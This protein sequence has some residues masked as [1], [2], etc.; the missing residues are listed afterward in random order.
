MSAMNL[1]D[2]L[3]VLGEPA[4]REAFASFWD[5]A[6][7]ACPPATYAARHL[8]PEA[9]GAA[10]RAGRFFTP[11]PPAEL[12]GMARRIRETPAL[13]ALA[14]YAHWRLFDGPRQPSQAGWPALGACLGD[15][16]ELFYLVV[17]LGFIPS[18]Q[19][20]HRRLDLPASVMEGTGL[21]V[22]RYCDNFR[23]GRGR[24]GL[25]LNQFGWLANYMPPNLYFR[26]G[27][28]EYR[29]RTFQYPAHIF[30][31][32][33]D[34][35]T[36]ALSLGDLPFTAEGDRCL[37]DTPEP[38]GSWRS[39]FEETA[40][41]TRGT[42][43]TPWGRAGREPV[44]L[45]RDE[46]ECVLKPGDPILDMHIP[47]GGQMTPAAAESSMREAFHFFNTRF[48][49][50]PV[51][52]VVSCSW[53]FSNQIEAC[54][55]PEA[56]LAQLARRLYLLPS[57]SHANSGLW[58]VFLQDGGFN[59]ATARRDTSLQRA[60][61]DYLSRTGTPWHVNAMF[62]LGADLEAL[63]PDTY[64]RRWPPAGLGG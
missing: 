13:L 45:P 41:A 11:D 47:G 19:A 4:S 30:R 51:K 56:N 43:V 60:L 34:Q 49:E 10:W 54:L 44:R 23:R 52:A 14:A 6:R 38:P 48:P 39:V 1:D 50:P 64:R 7:C 3:A 36:V 31:R 26:I 58:F 21:Q 2:M 40:Q 18:V 12:L 16:A 33:S 29:K 9:I 24:L 63:G 57:P 27:R 25:Y 53:I 5:E 46:W 22:A 35:A 20:Y 15:D 28:F 42:P 32:R 8:A 62:V 17:A 61:L 37:S 55:P 59:P